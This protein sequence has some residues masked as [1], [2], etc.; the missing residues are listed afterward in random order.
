LG[1]VS[2]PRQSTAQQPPRGD[3]TG[4]PLRRTAPGTM[5]HRAHQARR[6]PWWF[7]SAG[8]RFDL[9][10]PRGTCYLASSALVAVR[11]RLGPVLAARESLP[12]TVLEGVVVSR[13][14][15]GVP[16][17]RAPLRLANLRVSAAAGFGV[18]RELESMTPYDVPVRWARAFDDLGLDGIWY[19]PRFSPGAASAVALFGAAGEDPRRPVDP[20]PVPAAEVRGVPVAVGVPRRRDLKVIEPPRGGVSRSR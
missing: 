15:V 10:Q 4:F 9:A 13:L 19:G 11:E 5:L 20:Q 3:L 14:A 1:R 7:A 17:E 18:T 6:G 12:A 2:T 16:G 8:G